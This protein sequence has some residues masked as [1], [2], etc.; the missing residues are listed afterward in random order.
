MLSTV[1][2]R[3]YL[4]ALGQART[5]AEIGNARSIPFLLVSESLEEKYEALLL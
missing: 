3:K 4:Y 1:L 2:A 5:G